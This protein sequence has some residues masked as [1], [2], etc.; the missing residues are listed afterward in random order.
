M[1][2]RA[3]EVMSIVVGIKAYLAL[4]GCG[5]AVCLT[6]LAAVLVRGMRAM[7]HSEDDCIGMV[8]AFWLDATRGDA[9][10]SP[11]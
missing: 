8:K 3:K 4:T 10:P 1:E 9:E 6:A 7:G 11:N 2:S 5:P